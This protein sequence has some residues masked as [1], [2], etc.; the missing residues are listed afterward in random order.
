MIFLKKVD[1]LSGMYIYEFIDDNE[2]IQLVVDCENSD[3][4]KL[5]SVLKQLDKDSIQTIQKIVSSYMTTCILQ[6]RGAT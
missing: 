2:T 5:A 3:P 1:L 6:T 4:F